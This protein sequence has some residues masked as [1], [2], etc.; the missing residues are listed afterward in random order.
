MTVAIGKDH[1][2]KGEYSIC[3]FE[4]SQFDG[5]VFSFEVEDGFEYYGETIN[6]DVTKLSDE[7]TR[8]QRVFVVKRKKIEVAE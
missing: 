4:K 1:Q 7:P 3:P 5:C 2:A 8:T 6:V